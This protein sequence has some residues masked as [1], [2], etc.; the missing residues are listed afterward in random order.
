MRRYLRVFFCGLLFGLASTCNVSLAIAQTQQ[1]GQGN[2]PIPPG[3]QDQNGDEGKANYYYPAPQTHEIYTSQAATLSDSTRDRRIG[4]VIG[5]T[6]Q[7]LGNPY[8]PP[9]AIFA[10][11]DEA[12]RLIVVSLT[13]SGYNTLYRARA[14]FAMLTA[15]ARTTPFFRDN[16]VDDIFNFF[17]LCKL[18]GFR[19]IIWTDGRQLAHE[20]ILK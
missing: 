11:G 6:Q 20:V 10:K 16:A 5:L 18:L 15:T 14:L 8:P 17:D 7:I 12:Q 2:S 1:Q 4:F 19:E 3:A 9:F 13:D